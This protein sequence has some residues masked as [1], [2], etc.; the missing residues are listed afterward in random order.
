M[1]ALYLETFGLEG[2]LAN[3]LVHELASEQAS[4][5]EPE[6]ASLLEISLHFFLYPLSFYSFCSI[7]YLNTA[8][9]YPFGCLSSL[10]P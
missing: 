8:F 1:L 2:V 7:Y 3:E 5:P 9:L 10:F 4:E 6:P